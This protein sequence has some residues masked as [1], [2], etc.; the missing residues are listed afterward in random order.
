M[1]FYSRLLYYNTTT[2]L[3]RSWLNSKLEKKSED[4]DTIYKSVL[5][6]S[7]KLLIINWYDV[8]ND[9]ITD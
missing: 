8:S 4:K 7:I 9:I 5:C 2:T 1:Q 6:N 3:S